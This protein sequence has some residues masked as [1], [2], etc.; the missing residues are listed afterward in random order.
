[1]LLGI[2]KS[3]LNKEKF[4]MWSKGLRQ[5]RKQSKII[6]PERTK[7]PAEII[8]VLKNVI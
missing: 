1:M 5:W 7:G 8:G 4:K 3:V 6:Q 2:K